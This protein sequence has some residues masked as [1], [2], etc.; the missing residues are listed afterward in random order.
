MSDTPNLDRLVQRLRESIAR[1]AARQAQEERRIAECESDPNIMEVMRIYEAL[2]GGFA[3]DAVFALRVGRL[4]SARS[5]DENKAIDA[6]AAVY[7]AGKI[8]GV[9]EERAKRR[10]KAVQA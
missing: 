1:N 10:R 5:S 2:D 3:S 6:C 7:L 8:A 4:A 9:R